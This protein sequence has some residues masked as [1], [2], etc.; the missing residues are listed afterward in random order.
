M[1]RLGLI[2]ML[3][4]GVACGDDDTRMNDA[5]TTPTDGGT[6]SGQITFDTGPEPDSGI[7]LVDAGPGGTDAG[8]G[9]TDAGPTPACAT[10][11]PPVLMGDQVP[12]CA[13]ATLTCTQGCADQACFD[14]CLTSDA[15]PAITLQG[16][17]V[18]CQT[19]LNIQFGSCAAANGCQAEWGEFQCC[20]ESCTEQACVTTCQNMFAPAFQAC[21][22]GAAA[23]CPLTNPTL[24]TCF[25]SE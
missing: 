3:A 6:D 19:C 7:V 12:R 1:T 2:L 4:L 18:N 20:A 14:N 11:P 8:P 16:Q 9:G 24:Q 25:A 10:T 21:A 15:T 22:M 5:G 23:S 17:E 13:A